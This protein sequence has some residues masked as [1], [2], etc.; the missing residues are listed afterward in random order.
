MPIRQ[1]CWLR[2]S[3]LHVGDQVS[4]VVD[5]SRRYWL[6][7]ATGEIGLDARLLRAGDALGF[8]E[9]AGVIDLHGSVGISDVL[10]LDL[11]A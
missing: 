1:R 5:P 10:M 6:H 3:R 11:P 8:I 9:E 4:A 2:A 7:V